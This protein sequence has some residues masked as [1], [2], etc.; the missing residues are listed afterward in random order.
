MDIQISDC[1]SCAQSTLNNRHQTSFNIIYL[2]TRSTKRRKK[3]K[4]GNG[5]LMARHDT[6]TFLQY[7]SRQSC[8]L[9]SVCSINSTFSNRANFLTV[10][11][12][13]GSD[14][15]SLASPQVGVLN[16]QKLTRQE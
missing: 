10:D 6:L 14:V 1:T 15:W 2:P 8:G 16:K 3:N 9:G 4:A 13:E 7:V 11:P 12:Q 5:S